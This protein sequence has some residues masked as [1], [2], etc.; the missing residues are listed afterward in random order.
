MNALRA[1]APRP[2]LRSPTAAMKPQSAKAKGR[3]LQQLV[4]SDLLERFPSL[5]PADV[6]STSMGASGEDVQLSAAARRLIPYS[7]EA[8]NQE[9]LNLWT[10]IEQSRANTPA[11]THPVVVFKRNNEKPHVALR[12]DH[13]V[14]LIAAR[15]VPAASSPSEQLLALASQLQVLAAQLR[16]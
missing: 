11:E 5:T 9:R 12:W 7:F 13:F 10:A 2:L 6:R 1:R 4:V 8:K 14:D 3:R 15:H 16:A